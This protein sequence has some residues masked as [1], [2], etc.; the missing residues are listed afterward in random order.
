MSTMISETTQQGDIIESLED[1]RHAALR[2]IVYDSEP[3]LINL[4][5]RIIQLD[6]SDTKL[7]REK[8]DDILGILYEAIQTQ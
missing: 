7:I 5:S 4:G 6:L 3:T 2:G 1:L 8:L